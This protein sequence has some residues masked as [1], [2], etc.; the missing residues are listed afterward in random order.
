MDAHP[1]VIDKVND[2]IWGMVPVVARLPGRRDD[3]PNDRIHVERLEYAAAAFRQEL[4]DNIMGEVK[5][6]V[7]ISQKNFDPV[8]TS[9]R[10]LLEDYD[11]EVH[12]PVRGEMIDALHA[13]GAQQT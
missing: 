2:A 1:S 5:K 6:V 7:D 13:N 8:Y 12:E 10:R 4:L 9:I 3:L 11:A